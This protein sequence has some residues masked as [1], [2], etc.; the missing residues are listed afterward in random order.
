M[1][2]EKFLS[3]LEYL[4]S[5]LPEEERQEALQY[6]R[7][8]FDDAGPERESEILSELGS[9]ER[10]AAELKGS[11][12]GQEDGGE[13]SERGYRAEWYTEDGHVPDQY[14]EVVP[15]RQIE[16]DDSQKGRSKGGKLLILILFLIF[17]LPLAGTILS[18]G[19]SVL[20]AILAAVFGGAAGLIG[21]MIGAGALVAALFAAGLAMII[22]GCVGITALP[23]GIMVIGG[24]FLV[25]GIAFLLAILVK[26]GFGTMMPA[27]FRCCIDLIRQICSWISAKVCRLL[28]RGGAA[29]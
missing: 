17:G 14:T 25:L 23:V 26:W 13:F 18:A 29:E 28:G 19:A 7:D 21:L 20:L 4:L 3:E 8:Y 24:G 6:Y 11:L 5:D 1:G 16:A 9:P 27:L 2:R 12:N 15:G 22:A 10:T